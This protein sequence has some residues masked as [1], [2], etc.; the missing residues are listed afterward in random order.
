MVFDTIKM[1]KLKRK[2]MVITVT[3]HGGD[4]WCN[5]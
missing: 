3:S 2:G 1:V 5:G 4:A